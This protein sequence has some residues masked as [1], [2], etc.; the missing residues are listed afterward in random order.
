MS[1]LLWQAQA[2][3]ER[4]AKEVNQLA[5]GPIG[6]IGLKDNL[7]KNA[8]SKTQVTQQFVYNM[9]YS[10]CLYSIHGFHDYQFT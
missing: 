1:E 2:G 9:L 7:I 4:E 3:K 6:Q 5:G 8:A 10:F